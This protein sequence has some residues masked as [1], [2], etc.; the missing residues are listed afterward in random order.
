M[1]KRGRCKTESLGS[2]QFGKRKGPQWLSYA[3]VHF[4]RPVPHAAL[5][6]TVELAKVRNWGRTFA[7]FYPLPHTHQSLWL[8]GPLYPHKG[9][10]VPSSRELSL[11]YPRATQGGDSHHCGEG[12]GGEILLPASPLAPGDLLWVDPQ[13]PPTGELPDTLA[14][15]WSQSAC[16][17][18]QVERELPHHLAQPL[19]LPEY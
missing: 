10:R 4:T 14:A 12:K 8:T 5:C 16:S 1:A 7:V 2:H 17:R 18:R 19:L 13:T 11:Q 15:G 6:V 9:K 3:S